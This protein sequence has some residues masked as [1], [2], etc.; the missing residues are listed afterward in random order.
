[1]WPGNFKPTPTHFFVKL[2]EQK[3]VLRRC[4]TQVRVLW[5][6]DVFSF[7]T[8][9]LLRVDRNQVLVQHHVCQFCDLYFYR[10][11]YRSEYLRESP[12]FHHPFPRIVITEHRHPGAGSWHSAFLIGGSPRVFR[13]RA[14]RGMPRAAQP[15]LFEVREM[16]RAMMG[17][18]R[19]R[20]L[21]GAEYSS[22]CLHLASL[23]K[24]IICHPKDS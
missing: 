12:N 16:C 10:Y 8:M 2:L 21:H 17:Y 13:R 14:L 19:T 5:L 15:Q 24:Q 6:A 7:L 3:K 18:N 22:L 23:L 4:F 11:V 9:A 20:G 1:M